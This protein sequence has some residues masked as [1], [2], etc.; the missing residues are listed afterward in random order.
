MGKLVGGGALLLLALF[1][2][3]GY[4][5]SDADASATTRAL[6]LL[7]TVGLPG[8]AGAAMLRSHFGARGRLDQRKDVLRQQTMESEILRLAGQHDGKLTLVE[9]MS[10]LALPQAGAKDLLDGM[11]MREV[12]DVEVTDSGVLVYSFHDIRHLSEKSTSRG[13]LDA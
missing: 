12:A 6:T 10:A 7:L 8:F 11:V 9:V 4:M 2:L 1:M 5:G 3:V 13:V